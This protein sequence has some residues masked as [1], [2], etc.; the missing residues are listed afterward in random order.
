MWALRSLGVRRVL[1]P[2]SA[3][4][5]PTYGPGTLVIPGQLVDRTRRASRPL[6]RSPPCRSPTRTPSV[7]PVAITT[8]RSGAGPA[9]DAGR[10]RGTEVPPAAPSRGSP[11]RAGPWRYDRPPRGRLARELALCT[12]LASPTPQAS[13]KVERDPGW[14]CSRSAANIKRL[15]DLVARIISA[16]SAAREDDSARTLDGISLPSTS[17]STLPFDLPSTPRRL[18]LGPGRPAASMCPK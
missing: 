9:E 4:A 18:P 3:R 17:P 8:A 10:H 14:K 2:R 16:T 6:R 15:R 12:P 5:P 11:P 1:R 13:R 7:R